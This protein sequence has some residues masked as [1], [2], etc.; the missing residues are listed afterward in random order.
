MSTS[1]TQRVAEA[2]RAEAARRRVPQRSIAAALG[3][4]QQSVS[5]RMSGETP[6][7]V[8]EIHNLAESFGVSFAS[9]IPDANKTPA[10]ADGVFTQGKA[11]A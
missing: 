5:R 9:L 10:L 6:F 2:V 7:D 11:T 8:D 3:T 4:S 1:F